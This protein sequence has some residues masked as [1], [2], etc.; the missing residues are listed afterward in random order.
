MGAGWP[1]CGQ[2]KT[3]LE[4]HIRQEEQDIFPR[5]GQ[6]WDRAR[7]EEAGREMR[8]SKAEKAG[9][10]EVAVRARA[11]DRKARRELGRRG[12]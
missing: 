1:P 8:Q 3:A 7:L 12:E 2:I 5:I 10:D 9:A 6:I 4:N 11:L